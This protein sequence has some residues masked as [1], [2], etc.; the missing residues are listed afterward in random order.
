MP[1]PVRVFSDKFRLSAFG[2]EEGYDLL[3][4]G[5][6]AA[7]YREIPVSLVRVDVDVATG[8][9]FQLRIPPSLV[10]HDLVDLWFGHSVAGAGSGTTTLQ[11][12]RVRSGANVDM[13]T[14]PL[15]IDSTELGSDTATTQPEI[16]PANDDL[17]LR[18]QLLFVVEGLPA[19]TAP[20]GLDG[21]LVTRKPS[22]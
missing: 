7:T 20:Q 3:A 19:T 12:Q 5:V 14:T 22:S 10:G 2:Y 15:T 4:S 8:T 18:D 11:I 9:L 16:D 6:W 21:Y 17:A 13:L 1:N